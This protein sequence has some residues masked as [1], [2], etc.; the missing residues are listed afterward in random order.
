MEGSFSSNYVQDFF[1][2]FMLFSVVY[3]KQIFLLQIYTPFRREEK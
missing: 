3:F 1:A 2:W